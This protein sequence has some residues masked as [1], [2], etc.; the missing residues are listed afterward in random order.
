[1]NWKHFNF[2]EFECKCGCN[3]NDIDA[4]FVDKLDKLRDELG[5]PFII[6]SG[7]RCPEYNN[8]ISSTGLA[9]PHTTGR[10]TD[11]LA[12]RLNAIKILSAAYDA[13]FKGFGV[14]QKGK[15]RFIHLDDIDRQFPT[16]WSY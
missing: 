9:G 1:M 14:N 7:Y 10:A 15:G 2:K 6:T 16:I 12:N 8:K 3:S 11:I 4:G 13:G 5:F